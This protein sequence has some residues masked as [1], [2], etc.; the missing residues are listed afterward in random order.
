M[1]RME[2]LLSS[3]GKNHVTETQATETAD[4]R[5]RRCSRYRRARLALPSAWMSPVSTHRLD[6]RRSRTGL[7][8][9]RSTIG[10]HLCAVWLVAAPAVVRTSIWLAGAVLLGLLALRTRRS[11]PTRRN[12]RWPLAGIVFLGAATVSVMAHGFSPVGDA[13]LLRFA[14]LPVLGIAA[15]AVMRS[16]VRHA[17]WLGSLAGAFAALAS[18]VSVVWM[19]GA[20]RAAGATTNA[21]LFGQLSLVVAALALILCPTM[22]DVHRWPTQLSLVAF[23]A[24][25]TASSLSASRGPWLALPLVFGILAVQFRGR[26]GWRH[27]LLLLA[28]V[29]ASLS[30]AGFLGGQ[31]MQRT[32]EVVSESVDYFHSSPAT[33][34]RATSVGSRLDIWRTAADGFTAEPVLGIGWGNLN[35]LLVSEARSGVITDYAAEFSHAHNQYLS[36]LVSGGIVGLMALIFLLG[37]PGVAFGHALFAAEGTNRT[38]GAAGLMVVGAY[39]TFAL[40]ESVF[41]RALPAAF[42][43]LVVSVLL[44]HLQPET[45]LVPPALGPMPETGDDLVPIPG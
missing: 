31:E 19:A 34:A 38:I 3:G 13:V 41:E 21:I 1:N 5:G 7:L 35:A 9:D 26:V 32:Q 40:T 25:A 28:C 12:N 11:L 27:A 45:T 22:A 4:R 17:L 6:A 20:E 2:L 44:G 43:A 36:V 42:F 39:A 15:A 14:L 30:A 23:T 24:G 29:G 33:D 8:T 37:V 16:D 10:A 18:S